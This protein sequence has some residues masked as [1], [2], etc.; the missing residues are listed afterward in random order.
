M[1]FHLVE[2]VIDLKT[3]KPK[4]IRDEEITADG[5]YT[6]ESGDRTVKV[7]FEIQGRFITIFPDKSQGDISRAELGLGPDIIDYSLEK[8]SIEGLIPCF[9][10]QL[11]HNGKAFISLDESDII[12]PTITI[13][14]YEH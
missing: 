6:L 12:L 13:E 9:E 14:W 7:H 1:A 8:A 3:E 5:S 4:V 11:K 10:A 2:R